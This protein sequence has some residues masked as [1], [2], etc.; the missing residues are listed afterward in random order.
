MHVVKKFLEI[1][2]RLDAHEADQQPSSESAPV[3]PT[4]TIHGPGSNWL[5]RTFLRRNPKRD[6]L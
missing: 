2:Q 3:S 1:E 4:P 5:A 6:G